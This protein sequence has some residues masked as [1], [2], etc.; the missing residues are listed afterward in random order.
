[1]YHHLS[2]CCIFFKELFSCETRFSSIAWASYELTV[3]LPPQHPE[4]W[5]YRS[6]RLLMTEVFFFKTHLLG[7]C[8]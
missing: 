3:I 6:V 1:M 5:D 8:V 7:E 2:V 4:C